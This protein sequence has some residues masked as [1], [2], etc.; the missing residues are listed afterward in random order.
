MADL[1][2]HVPGAFKEYRIDEVVDFTS[3]AA[4]YKAISEAI[5]AGSVVLTAGATVLVT[6]V[7]GGTADSFGIGPQGS[8][9]DKYGKPAS[10]GLTAGTTFNLPLVDAVLTSAETIH[11]NG[12][13][14]ATG[15][16]GDGNVTAGKVRVVLTYR[17]ADTIP[18]AL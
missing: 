11:V 6:L 17:T 16:L 8:D 1:I 2:R 15:A 14:Q 13:V 12:I 3:N 5:P 4:A 9:P 7:D 18:A 10:A